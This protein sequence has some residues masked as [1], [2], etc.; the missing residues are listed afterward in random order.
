MYIYTY[1]CNI[2]KEKKAMN[3]KKSVEGVYGEK[4][5]KGEIMHFCFIFKNN[6]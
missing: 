3:L 1:M 5:K 4:K 6:L 2:I